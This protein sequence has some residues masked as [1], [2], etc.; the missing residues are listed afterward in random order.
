VTDKPSE[1]GDCVEHSRDFFCAVNLVFHN[2]ICR[3]SKRPEFICPW[4]RCP[5]CLHSRVVSCWCWFVLRKKIL[6]IE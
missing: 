5:N 6:M 3:R 4:L 2:S 1:H